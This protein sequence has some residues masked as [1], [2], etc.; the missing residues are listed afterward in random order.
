[1]CAPPPVRR[2]ETCAGACA[3]GDGPRVAARSRPPLNVREPAG[4]GVISCVPSSTW[5]AEEVNLQ[6]VD[7]WLT[8]KRGRLHAEL[9]ACP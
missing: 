2:A 9:V 8:F 5:A 3:P 1:M 4:E 6:Q 7:L